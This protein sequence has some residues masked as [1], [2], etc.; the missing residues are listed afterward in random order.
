MADEPQPSVAIFFDA[1]AYSEAHGRSGVKAGPAG[2]MGRQVAGKEF[3]D[4]YLQY[5]DWESL[6]DVVRSRERADP[7][8][9]LFQEHPSSRGRSRRLLIQLEADFLADRFGG[10]RPTLPRL[11][12]IPLGVNPL[13]FAPQDRSNDS[14]SGPDSVSR[15]TRSWSCVSAV[16]PITRRLIRILRSSQPR[17]PHDELAKKSCLCSPAR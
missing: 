15:Q 7:L 14:Q 5:G 4:G 12:M 9:Q 13:V 2:L 11:E 10:T 3:L 17:R 6:P 16:C 8:I 1:H